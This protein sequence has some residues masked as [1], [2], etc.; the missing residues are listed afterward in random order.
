MMP[1]GR[2]VPVTIDLSP[3]HEGLAR[4]II[5]RGYRFE[6]EVLRTGEVSAEIVKNVSDPDI[7]DSLATEICSNGPQVPVSISKMI[8]DAARAIGIEITT[9]QNL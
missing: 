3:M 7:D 8:E 5:S 9:H 4:V 6:I 1:N 2:K